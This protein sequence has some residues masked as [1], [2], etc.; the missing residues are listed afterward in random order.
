MHK[1]LTIL[2]HRA[3]DHYL[4]DG[5]IICLRHQAKRLAYSFKV[6]ETLR[7]NEI[8]IFQ[9]VADRLVEAFP[10]ESEKILEDAIKHWLAIMRYCAMALLLNNPEYLDH[11]IL[12]WLTDQVQAHQMQTIESKLYKILKQQLESF[13]PSQEYD[14]LMPFLEQVKNTLFSSEKAKTPEAVVS[15]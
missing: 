14:V 5:E 13:L 6:Y 4:N 11:H 10:Q 15:L 1:D 2:L 3:E 12:E 9:P 7:D 8:A